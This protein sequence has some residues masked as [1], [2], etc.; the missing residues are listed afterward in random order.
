[1][2]KSKYDTQGWQ[3]DCFYYEP[4]PLCFGCRN[5]GDHIKCEYRCGEAVKKNVC[6]SNYHYPKNFEKMI[7]RPTVNIDKDN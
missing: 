1:M 4:C 5:Y 3:T 6:T 2:P 7:V